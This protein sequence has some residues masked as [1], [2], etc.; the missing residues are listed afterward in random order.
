MIGACVVVVALAAV[1]GLWWA[2][3][4]RT[5]P[6]AGVGPVSTAPVAGASTDPSPPT[7]RASAVAPPVAPPVATPTTAALTPATQTTAPPSVAATSGHAPTKSTQLSPSP[8]PRAATPS[9][10]RGPAM[11]SAPPAV[12]WAATVRRLDVARAKALIA[13]DPALLD[14]VY[15]KDSAA[16]AAD[17]KVISSLVSGGVRVSGAQHVVSTARAVGSAPVRVDVRDS[18]PSYSI[19]DTA[20]SVVGRTRG[21][22][23]ASRILVLV[24]TAGGYRI[25]E[26]LNS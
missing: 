13:R 6:L 4:E 20:G 9:N 12:D 17:A 7:G 23:I 25:S 11:T 10:G 1:G 22:S 21:R 19:V 14:A 26:V 5:D 2:G 3:A 8:G 15:T 24:S 16:R 18:L